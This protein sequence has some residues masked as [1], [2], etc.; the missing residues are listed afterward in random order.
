[1]IDDRA[2]LPP[3]ELEALER[4]VARQVSL[5]DVIRWAVEPICDVVVQDEYT[6]DI[7]V[8]WGARWLVYD[9]T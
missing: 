4:A 8:P 7:V 9:T 2:G 1:V 6:H 3:T 5:A